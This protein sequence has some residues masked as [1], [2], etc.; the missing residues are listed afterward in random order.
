[1]IP[2]IF[3]T[4][5]DDAAKF[6][7]HCFKNRKEIIAAGLRLGGD[8][9]ADMTHHLDMGFGAIRYAEIA[10]SKTLS[11]DVFLQQWMT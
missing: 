9:V 11:P 6:A 5:A 7:H 1:M 2:P 4:L 8:S 3:S 10:P